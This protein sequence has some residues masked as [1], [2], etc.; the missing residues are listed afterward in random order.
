MF[1]NPKITVLVM[2]FAAFVL[3]YFIRGGS[4]DA[5][6]QGIS[7]SEEAH[8][9]FWTCS[10]HPQIQQPGSGQCPLCAMD[11]ISVTDNKSGS[12][13]ERECKMSVAAMKLAGVQTVPVE[14]KFVT[15]EIRMDGKIVYDE[16]RLSYITAWVPGR[17][18][19]M[20]V[21]YTG[22]PVRK[23]DHLVELY[24]PELI[25]AQQ[26]L[27]LGLKMLKG[28]SGR[29]LDSTRRNV[30]AT[31]EKLRLWGLSERQINQVEKSRKVSERTT[32][33]SP[34]RG[35]VVQK[36]GFEGMYV[37]TGTRIYTVADLDHVWVK[38]DAYESDLGWIRY[39]QKVEFETDAYPGEP[40]NGKIMFID[41]V[42]DAKTRTVKVRVNVANPE[43]KLKPEMFVTARVYPR[44]AA[45]GRVMDP[46][47]KDKWICSM[48]PEIVKDQQAVCDICGM[49]LVTAVSMG[50]MS[51][52]EI[53][54]EA[55]LVIPVSAPLITG[56]RA[57]VYVAVPGKEG[58]FE[59]REIV[60]GPRA[61][62]YYQVRE[63]LAEGDQVVTQGNF[64]IDSAIQIMAKPS[65]MNPEGGIGSSG[66]EHHGESG[67]QTQNGTAKL[68]KPFVV[69]PQFKKQID[70]LVV[71]YY[72]MHAGLKSDSFVKAAAGAKAFAVRLD[73][74]DMTLVKGRAQVAWME[75]CRQLKKDAGAAAAAEDIAALRNVFDRLSDTLY[76]VVKQFG[77]T[78][79]FPVYR[80]FCPMF[81]NNK[82]AYWLQQTEQTENPY[83]GSMMYRCGSLTE[84]V[85]E[86]VHGDAPKGHVHE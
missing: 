64:K 33:Y 52:D 68:Q 57:V 31:R 79:T 84:T 81:K 46:E 3:G 86:S 44:V 13:G 78:G 45:G 37:K 62:V 18:E 32:I 66:H 34:I 25:T 29:L 65:M 5:P 38:L 61:G 20:F 8:V 80:F 23:G 11:L 83:Y 28:Q 54:S 12:G 36:N 55:P 40:F 16:T 71:V 74:I 48:H 42:L 10:M 63:G 1:K 43:G 76:A 75:L 51:S 56:R 2:L 27:L 69:D 77:T 67:H 70:P 14:R 7:V 41:P 21:D 22:V 17:I 60:L 30:E 9:N 39:G 49:A 24:S 47:L 4:G 72:E 15:A 58:S 85:V 35:I 82:G 6:K 73:G 59:G 50:Y 19:R 53:S 26:E